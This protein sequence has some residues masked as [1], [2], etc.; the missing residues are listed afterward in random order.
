MQEMSSERENV[1]NQLQQL[2]SSCQA[3][4]QE[5]ETMREELADAS[6]QRCQ[7]KY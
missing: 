4:A 1:N 7:L 5:H 6:K 2:A 3:L